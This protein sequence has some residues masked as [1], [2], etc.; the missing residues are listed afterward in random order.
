SSR[1]TP[2]RSRSGTP[3]SRARRI[4]SHTG[5]KSRTTRPTPT[6][7][8]RSGSASFATSTRTPPSPGT[9]SR[10]RGACSSR[11][12]RSRAP[13][14]AV[15]SPF[16][17]PGPERAA[18]A[19]P[20]ADRRVETYKPRPP[21]SWPARPANPLTRA[22]IAAAHVVADPLAECDPWLDAP[23]DWDATIAYRRHLWRLGFG[24]AE[25]MDTAQRGMGLDWKTSL[26]L[27]RRSIES[28]KSEGAVVFSGA[29]TDHLPAGHH[30]IDVIIR[31]YEEQIGA[32]EQLGG[33][34][35]L[36]ASRAL[37]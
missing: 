21:R 9:C 7:S 17:R 29:G 15:G 23:M 36:M 5:R 16:P 8:A 31:A 26:E 33:R 25:A 37:A 32:I 22:A 24:V 30:P 13:P 2:R 1:A 6:A 35:I 14:S 12:S 10:A 34:V 18:P 19:L 11:S 20:P 28:A 27:I 3:M 4:S